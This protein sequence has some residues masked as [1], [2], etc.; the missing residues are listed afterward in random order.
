MWVAPFL[1][2]RAC[3]SSWTRVGALSATALAIACGDSSPAD[4][5]TDG[6]AGDSSSVQDGAVVTDAAP[7]SS[8]EPFG[9]YPAPQNTFTLPIT[10]GSL[11]IGDVQK[12]F[13]AVDWTTL[14]RLYIP[15]G[16]YKQLNL[17]NFPTRD[18]K[19]P[20]IITNL[21]GQVQVGPPGDG[22]NYVWAMGGG[23]NWILTGRYDPDAKTGDVGFPGHRCGAYATSRGKYGFFSDDAYAKGQYS[24]MGL[25]V[26]DA[27]D[28]E[29]EFVEVTRAGF[30]GI[31]L[32][33]SRTA[34]DPARPM[35]NVRVHDTY[36]HDSASEAFYFG[37]T[38][39]PPGNM[40]PNL[41]V[42]NNRLI[43][44]GSEGLQI[45]DLGDKTHVHHN[46][47]AFNALHWLDNFG[48]YQDGASQVHT[49]EGNI[50]LDHNVV[51]GGA[52]TFLSL[53]SAP[54]GADGARNVTLHD[55]YFADTRSLGGYLN[56]TSTAP[57]SITLLGNY[58]RGLDFAYT[59]VDPA[60]K[61]PGVVFGMN[62]GGLK[63]PILFDGNHWEGNRA[64]VSGMGPDQV[65]GNVTT[66]GNVN[67]PVPVLAFIASG[68]PDVPTAR[69]S[70]WGAKATLA[71]GQPAISYASGD[72]VMEDGEM[73]RAR[74]TSTNLLPPDHPEA[75]EKLPLPSDDVRVVA[76]S[77]YAGYG[78]Q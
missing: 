78:V 51:V 24:H 12:A 61:D 11:A 7:P 71:P 19:R 59:A 5:T 21:G 9:H 41:Q 52:G 34:N 55:N 31:R 18:A 10:N 30:A 16:K 43:R 47:V 65:K 39:A 4:P 57:S 33:N 1:R 29:L 15:A 3:P 56:G 70:A 2:M 36:V 73:Y 37:W 17:T 74:T 40:L 13:P 32:L 6:G 58:F 77:P 23:S 60:A 8:C 62:S 42:Y 38:G 48:N 64:I 50:E 44:S 35:A 54:E 14:D 46:T 28:F 27:T 49:R 76:N 67:A 63:G 25:A 68:Y 75:W 69:L 45:Q 66:K 22:S 53:F 20:L 72:L 26:G